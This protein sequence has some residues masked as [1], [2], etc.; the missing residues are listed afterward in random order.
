MTG[1]LQSYLSLD[2]TAAVNK[3]TSNRRRKHTQYP[4]ICYKINVLNRCYSFYGLR[5]WIFVWPSVQ[6]QHK[7]GVQFN[8]IY[9]E[10]V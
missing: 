1:V 2:C 8:H 10:T 9:T 7:T 6:K 3:W 5:P 4:S